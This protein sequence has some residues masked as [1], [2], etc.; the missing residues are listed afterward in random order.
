MFDA[1]TTIHAKHPG[2]LGLLT[3]WGLP[4]TIVT[5]GCGT[6]IAA[7][8]TEGNLAELYPKFL[9]DFHTTGLWPILTNDVERP[10]LSREFLL[11]P[12]APTPPPFAGR[13]RARPDAHVHEVLLC[14]GLAPP[15]ALVLVPTQRPADVP[16]ALGWL[17]SGGLTGNDIAGCL[18]SWEDRYGAILMTI[19]HDNLE[20]LVTS[21]PQTPAQVRELAEEIALVCPGIINP[22]AEALA[23]G[24]DGMEL[25]QGLI[26]DSDTWYFWWD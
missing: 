7:L 8:I 16:A 14:P 6:P 13:F 5:A 15:T 24:S 4:H 3:T 10:W 9:Q 23:P 12:L 1:R 22:S 25:L 19:G 11:G 20:L 26:E 18:R 17:G 2:N 21:P